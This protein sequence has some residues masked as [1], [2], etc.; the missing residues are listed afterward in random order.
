MIFQYSISGVSQKTYVSDENVDIKEQRINNRTIIT[1]I[2]KKE[3]VLESA[4]IEFK[5]DHLKNDLIFANGYQGWTL[6]K[7][8]LPNEH[9]KDLNKVPG[10]LEKKYHFKQYGSQSFKEMPNEVISAFDYAYIK[11]K[12]PLFIG[13]KNFKN[14]YLIIDFYRDSQTIQLIS[15]ISNKALKPKESFV[16]YDYMIHEQVENG[17]R[18]YFGS[19][20]LRTNQKLFGYTSWY[21]HYQNINEDIIHQALESADSRFQL[22]QIDD[23]YETYVGDWLDVD[24]KKFPNGL[25]PVVKKIHEKNMLAGLWIAPFV[26]ETKSK[27]RNQHPSWIAKDSCGD[28]IYA[29]CN[30]SM[31]F[32]LDLNNPEV[33]DYIR[34]VLRTYVEMG[35]DFFKLDF[36][37]ACN[38]CPLIGKT[39]AETSEFAYSLLREELKDKLILGCGCILSN[40]YEKFDYM[41]V[42]PDVSL[43]FDDIF[44]MRFFHPERVSTKVTIQN[45][46]YRYPMNGHATLNDPDVF[47]LR[48]H[49][50]DLNKDQRYALATINALFGSLL[51]TSDNPMDYDEDKQKLLNRTLELFKYGIVKGYKRNKNKILIHYSLNEKTY[52]ITYDTKKGVIADER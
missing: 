15:D 25:D 50:I 22:F 20:H 49:N 6:T 32:A 3:I 40:G 1:V 35:F 42:G 5:W 44:Y 31:D 19:F 23:G 48:D 47:L 10:F 38:L 52:Q 51:M 24:T 18:E 30:W 16:I 11:G 46:I 43:K 36:I 21:N 37:Y 26:C 17:L 33:V 39:R 28:F 2:A 7:E 45:T 14:A 13:S 8:F 4:C 9:I 29:G 34:K 41:R 12:K 27:L